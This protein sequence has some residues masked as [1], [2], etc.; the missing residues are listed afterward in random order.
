MLSS[1]RELFL[2][3]FNI[4]NYTLLF[5]HDQADGSFFGVSAKNKPQLIR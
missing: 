3:C 2:P 1:D 4:S 5:G